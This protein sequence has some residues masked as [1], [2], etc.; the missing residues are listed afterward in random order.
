MFLKKI[1]MS[2][3]QTLQSRFES[4]MHRHEGM[5]WK[6]I[7]ARIK[8]NPA[9]L[10]SLQAMEDSDGQPDVIHYDTTHDTYIFCDCSSESPK[11]RRSICFD[12]QAQ[13]SRKKHPPQNNAESLAHSMG[14]ELLDENMYRLLQAKEAVDTKTS[15]WIQTPTEIR[16]LGGALFADRRYNTVFIYH[17]G[18]DSYY[19]ARGFRG[20]LTI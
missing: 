18:A 17:N 5:S 1:E 2:L 20:M 15:S 11:G 7:E 12:S 16:S 10:H 6:A 8:N 14:I 9:A 4:N 19:A 3:L 13:V